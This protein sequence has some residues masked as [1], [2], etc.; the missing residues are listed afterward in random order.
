[1][2][3]KHENIFRSRSVKQMRDSSAGGAGAANDDPELAERLFYNL[4]SVDERG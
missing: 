3:I 4:C 2:P 1:L